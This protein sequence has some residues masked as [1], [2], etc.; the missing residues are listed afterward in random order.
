MKHS[1]ISKITALLLAVI[2][3]IGMFPTA[4]AAQDSSYHDPAEE[5][6]TALNR[7]NE[8]D[9]NAVIT[10]ETLHCATCKQN[11]TF[12]LFR[13]PEY[14]RDGITAMSRNVEYSDGTMID[15]ESVGSILDGTPGEDAFY[16]G[17]HWTKSVCETCGTING[18]IGRGNY[19]YDKNVYFLNDCDIA[20]F[21]DLE[22]EVTYEYTDSTY[23]TKTVKGGSYCVFCFG[24]YHTESTKLERHD[25][26]R[27]V[28]AELANQRFAVT[29][30]CADCG[31]AKKS[32]VLAKS[33]IAN[34]YGTADGEPH[35][36][37]VT[38]LSD[39]GVSTKIRYGTSADACTLTSAPNYTE[40][41]KYTVYYAITYAYKDEEMVENGVAYAW[42]DD[43]T[44]EENSICSCG[45]SGKNCACKDKSC[46]GTSCYTNNTDCGGKHS[47]ILLDSKDA[48]CLTLGYD[49][50]LCTECGTIE[51]R[52]YVN[53]LGHA[54]Q[55]VTVREATCETDGKVLEICANCGQ[56]QTTATP[57]GEHVY[58]TYS[59][60]ATC[61]APGYRVKECDV[62]GERSIT[63]ITS[64]K[65]HDY[66]VYVSPATCE[67]GGFTLRR[68][69]GCDSSFVSDYTSALGHKWNSGK[70]IAEASCTGEGVTEYKCTYCSASKLET[71]PATGHTVEGEAN[72]TDPQLCVTCGAV[73]EK[74][75][76]H[77]YK[78][79]VTAPTCKAMGYTTYTCKNC[80]DSYKG[81]YTDALGHDH[82]V[83]VTE[84]T[85]Y[86]DGFTTH[87]CSHCED[88]FITDPTEALGHE[89][90]KGRLVNSST[91]N[92]EGLIDY[93]CIRCDY[94]HLEAKSA[95]GHTPGKA[96]TCTEPQTCVGC[97]AFIAN[98][99]GHKYDSAVTAPTCTDMGY[100]TYTCIGCD[101]SYKGDYVSPIGHKESDWIIDR[102]PT[103]EKEGLK[104]KECE[105]CGIK[106]ESENVRRLYMTA[107]TDTYGEAVVGGYLVIVTDTDTNNPIA[108]TTV[109][110]NEDRTVSVRLPNS[111]VI[112]YDD[113]TTVTVLLSEDKAPVSG[114]KVS[115]TDKY[116]NYCAEKT[117]AS[118]K[119]TVPDG[120]GSTN[121]DGKTTIGFED[122]DGDRYTFTVK[123]E[124][125]ETA[126]PIYGADVTIGKTG[127][128]TVVLPNG[129]DM[130]KN[131]RITVTVTNN[132]KDPMEGLNVIVKNDLGKKEKGQTDE[133]GMLTVPEAEET[134]TEYHSAYI[135]GYE[136][137]TFGAERSMTRAEA[138]AIF[139]RLLAEKNDERIYSYGK[140]CFTDVAIDAW[141]AGYVQYLTKYGIIVGFANRTFRPDEAIT[142]AEF[143]V[144]AVRFFAVYSDDDAEVVDEYAI[145]KDVFSDYWAAEYIRSAACH[146]WVKGYDDDTFRAETFISR[147]EIVTLVNR[148]LGRTP[149]EEYIDMYSR[150]LN[151]FTDVNKRHF[152]YYE[153][154][155]SA[156]GHTA[157]YDTDEQWSGR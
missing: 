44:A 57:K 64:V 110:L 17:Y 108:N 121:S 101:E 149:D 40:K 5:W 104:H 30:E 85:C 98:A 120:D 71:I 75:M 119:I 39:A 88:T 48:T 13:T 69:D 83:T 139:A 52:N 81:N 31:Y 76:K 154:M 78:A 55:G 106:L 94:H 126:R 70:T 65:S 34:Y 19:A 118:G 73:T 12:L 80:D 35:T 22:D 109:T 18:N 114:M 43:E 59:V 45:C 26:E 147:A 130:D 113:Q 53:A 56:A 87:K 72:C 97:G 134:E 136:N 49:R 143:T 155:E 91:C 63:D 42:L 153:I 100:T 132:R 1:R 84:P 86:E 7:T 24:T 27:T 51:K 8:L 141:Y 41:G 144:M 115:V 142:R 112:D 23:H 125:Y 89:W 127:N 156:N 4:F 103:T 36:L 67:S 68:C 25:I 96:A 146:G 20:F 140:T 129:I 90:D 60:E 61:T 15:E 122:A 2:L 21:A 157:V 133:N 145:F 123:V 58:E 77:D 137:G 105:N 16:T 62:C 95:E 128:I 131:N 152:A 32:Y 28:E 135:V 92:A 107:T 50:Y 11:T 148:L 151:T 111:R 117:N 38:E 116:D 33:V 102:E 46:T 37:T 82:I 6:L 124:D 138:A 54:W 14:A 150:K 79:V 74:A 3:C 9:A 93:R 99:L 47:F 29:E 10:H 66:A